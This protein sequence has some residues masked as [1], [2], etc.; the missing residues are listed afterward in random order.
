MAILDANQRR[1]I[2]EP[3]FHLDGIQRDVSQRL[4]NGSSILRTA[5]AVATVVLINL[6][7]VSEP[8]QNSIELV[9]RPDQTSFSATFASVTLPSRSSPIAT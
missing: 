6:D 4:D 5:V 2:C 9:F 3:R 7:F 1:Q 8:T